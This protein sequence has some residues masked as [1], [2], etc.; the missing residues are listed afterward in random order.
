MIYKLIN[1]WGMSTKHILLLIGAA[2]ALSCFIHYYSFSRPGQ[3]DWITILSP[4]A[5]AVGFYFL[6]ARQRIS[7]ASVILGALLWAFNPFTT[8]LA[9]YNSANLLVYSMLAWL[10]I[11]ADIAYHKNSRIIGSICLAVPF[12]LIVLFYNLLCSQA[13]MRLFDHNPVYILPLNLNL[14]LKSLYSIINPLGTSPS[15][16]MFSFYYLPL[17]LLAAGLYRLRHRI[18]ILHILIFCIALELSIDASILSVPPSIWLCIAI[19]YLCVIITLG[20]DYTYKILQ[21][22]GLTI[23][24]NLLSVLIVAETAVL[25][26]L[27]ADK[28]IYSL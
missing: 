18:T 20:L 24:S 27:I 28:I 16:I 1:K 26:M 25:S 4:I 9:A 17:F 12:A 21:S 23:P 14:Q 13:I 10:F 15:N 19:L 3:T 6:L 22:A 7:P 8:T 11:P 5:S 2:S